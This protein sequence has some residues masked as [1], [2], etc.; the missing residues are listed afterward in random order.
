MAQREH[1]PVRRDVW[2]AR[3]RAHWEEH[4]F[5]QWVVERA[6]EASLIGVVGLSALSFDA[7]FTPAVEIAWRLARPY[8]GRGYAT[9]AARAAVDHSFGELDLSEIVAV[10]VPANQRSRM[11]M[12]HF[13]IRRSPE[14]DFDHPRLREGPLKRHVLYRLGNPE[15]AAAYLSERRG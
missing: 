7:P 3:A 1:R 6:S 14:G 15:G 4:G 13:G 5:G 9:E 12:E 11:V 2:T 10:T 8:W